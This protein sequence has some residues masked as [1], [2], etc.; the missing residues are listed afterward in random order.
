MSRQ[1]SKPP[2]PSGTGG[3]EQHVAIASTKGAAP[4]DLQQALDRIAD[5]EQKLSVANAARSDVEKAALAA[6]EAQGML[7]QRDVQEVATGKTVKVKRLKNYEVARLDQDGREVMRPVFQTVEVPTYFYKILLPPV[8]G[9]GLTTNGEQLLHGLVY[10]LDIDTL[11]SV[12]ERVYRLW[13]HERNIRGTDENF[14][15]PQLSPRLSGR[16]VRA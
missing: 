12:K 9:D 3:D 11:R 7:M 10:E 13:D 5:L 14:Y 15:R 2:V 6:A 4:A 16:G 1:A 8:G